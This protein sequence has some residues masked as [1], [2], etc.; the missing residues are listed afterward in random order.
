MKATQRELESALSCL[1][2]SLPNIHESTMQG[3]RQNLFAKLGERGALQIVYEL[4]VVT[5]EIVT[6]LLYDNVAGNAPKNFSDGNAVSD[7]VFA[8][9]STR[10]KSYRHTSHFSPDDIGEIAQCCIGTYNLLDG[11]FANWV[12]DDIGSALG[13]YVEMLKGQCEK[14]GYNLSVG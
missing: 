4:H 14:M 12:F 6:H 11:V 3:L 13:T 7:W 2:E 10:L 9:V 1:W 8:R 5:L